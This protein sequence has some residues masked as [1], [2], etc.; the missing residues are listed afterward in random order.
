MTSTPSHQSGVGS[1]QIGA[2][3]LATIATPGIFAASNSPNPPPESFESDWLLKSIMIVKLAKDGAEAIPFSF[4]K[5]VFG[6]VLTLL[7]T[8]QKAKENHDNL[9]EVCAHAL[10]IVQ[11]VDKMIKLHG[12]AI[13]GTFKDTCTK[14]MSF[15]E[16]LQQSVEQLNKQQSG[17]TGY[18]KRVLKADSTAA[19][20]LAYRE[21][22]K[23]L[24]ANFMM[25]T[26]IDNSAA[27]MKVHEKLSV[28]ALAN[29]NI[30]GGVSNQLVEP[31]RE[32][33]PPSPMFQ[34]R[35]NVVDQMHA[36][37]TQNIGHH[38][39]CV[40]YGLGGAGKTQTA[41]KF[42]EESSRLG[43]FS[44]V[45][46]IDTSTLGTLKLSFRGLAIAMH[47]GD[48]TEHA[49]QWLI[50]Q[51]T[52]WLLLFD[53]ADN[54]GIDLQQFMPRCSHGNI[55]ITTRNPGL[56]VH[57]PDSHYRL[58]DMEEA[59]AVE[60]L[61]RSSLTKSTPENK[62]IAREIVQVLHCFPLAIIQ[63]AAYISKTSVG[64]ERYLDLY[65]QN[66]AH[67]L[68]EKPAQTQDGY[69]F[70]VY[71]T[72]EISF[73]CLSKPAV[74]LLQLCSF[75]HHEGITET[76][77]SRAIHYK[78]TELGEL[79]PTT[80]DLRDAREFLAQFVAPSGTWDSLT[81][82]EVMAEIQGYSLIELDGQRKIYSIHPLVHTWTQ[83][84]LPDAQRTWHCVVTIIQMSG[85]FGFRDRSNQRFHVQCLPHIDSLL[86]EV[87]RTEL[88]YQ[89]TFGLIYYLGG[90]PA[91]AQQLL[92]TYA[93]IAIQQLGQEHPDT[94]SARASLAASY[95][96]LGQSKDAAELEAVV[97][98]K[99]KLLLGE[100]HPETLIA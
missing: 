95:K 11:H 51:Q 39:I 46:F 34:G 29:S 49:L 89:M 67:L 25:V 37:F 44:T 17:M 81:F 28:L 76:I 3:P 22:I 19:K 30:E 8:V 35:R 9:R 70:T 18:F 73:K 43:R 77:F 38:H 97:L 68:K 5:G 52:E 56:C 50:T 83:S 24:Q 20:I 65:M 88:N 7:E 45:F 53:N 92:S 58:S 10:E 94:L 61:L 54:T 64:L 96:A 63:A 98:E 1:G 85:P 79:G 47:A 90:Y 15:L 26:L 33:P 91:K 16:K 21:Q 86:T 57:A 78:G 32:C 40:L 2:L 66:R 13:A 42:V 31:L 93:G 59:D 6:M 14:F 82:E 41:L 4:V 55:L 60:L 87:K 80:E 99:S 27:L 74:Q 84:V 62:Q 100:E 48:T 36:Y 71:T 72:W 23:Q 12:D 69:A 75:L